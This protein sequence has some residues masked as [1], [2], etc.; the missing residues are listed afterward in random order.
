[1]QIL[2]IKATNDR[3]FA[4]H[5]YFLESVKDRLKDKFEFAERY[6]M[7]NVDFKLAFVNNADTPNQLDELYI[8][9]ETDLVSEIYVRVLQDVRAHLIDAGLTVHPYILT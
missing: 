2:T 3:D 8:S 1:M 6:G 9:F 4:N 7:P 5:P